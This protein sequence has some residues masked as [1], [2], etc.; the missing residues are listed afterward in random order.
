MTARSSP[1][2]WAIGAALATVYVIWGSTYLGIAVMIRTLPPLV[3]AG[4]RYTAAGLILLAVLVFWARARGRR[5]PRPTALHWRSA[6]VIGTLLLLGGNGGVVLG[7]QH[8]AS[9]IAALIIA[10]TPIWMNLFEALA[11]GQRPGWLTVAGLAA[12]LSGVA[13][14]VV[15]FG[16]S[17]TINPLGIVLVAGAAITWSIGS[18]YARRAPL[19]A[20]PLE[21]AGLQ[22]L[23]GGVA[24][25]VA[26]ALRG[27]LGDVDPSTFSTESILAVLYL[28]VFGSLVAFT[29]YIW[30][31]NHVSVSVVSTTAYVNPIVAVA[32]GV[33][34]LNE[35][36]TPRTWLAAVIIIGAV[37]AM[38]SGRPRS[39]S[40][41]EPVAEPEPEAL[42]E[43]DPRS[44][45]PET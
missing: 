39:V 45:A 43:T 34:L 35:P 13:I 19:P 25:F 1:S 33:V 7:E 17:E 36:M 20:S 8:I 12:G 42:L 28:I 37:V 23:A 6:I 26:G 24:L 31:L 4:V 15:P 3:A 44:G 40:E 30:L 21:G 16:S 2:P 27:E 10:T 14:L 5:I 22:M 29:A 41:P 38:V 32:L 18:I 11:A 9:G